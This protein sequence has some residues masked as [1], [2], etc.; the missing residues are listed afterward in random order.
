MGE[1]INLIDVYSVRADIAV[2]T[3]DSVFVDFVILA[4]SFR[5]LGAEGWR[6]ANFATLI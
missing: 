3:Q 6:R 1:N 2:A 5:L 4:S